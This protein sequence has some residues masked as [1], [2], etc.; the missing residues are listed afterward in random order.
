MIE[1][2]SREEVL[3]GCRK[4]LGLRDVDN[5]VV[6]DDL[7]T[8]LVRRSAG[9]HCPCSRTAL[10]GSLV[11]ALQHLSDSD[12]DLAD[13][14]ESII[15]GLIVVG[16]L[17]ELH[18]V[19]IVDP[20]VRGT[21]VFAAPPS[22]VERESGEI[23][24]IGIVADQDVFLPESFGSRVSMRGLTRLISP[25]VNENLAMKLEDQGLQRLSEK[26]WLRSPNT[27][28][29]DQVLARFE[30][31]LTE[32]PQAGIVNEIEILDGEQPVT[33]YRG[34][35]SDRT[36]KNGI[37]VGR[38]PQEYGA[39]IWCLVE[40]ASG[41]VIRF[42]DLP[43]SKSRWRGCDE[44]WHLQMA[45]DARSGQPQRYRVQRDAGDLRFDF[46]SPLPAWS[47]RRFVA[48]GRAVPRQ[49]CLMSYVLSSSAAEIEERFL[50]ECLWLSRTEESK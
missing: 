20:D 28:R 25:E 2:I 8:A 49:K 36:G 10:R 5:A 27:E 48:F 9:I 38:R 47:E 32:R 44:A 17:L 40:L 50:R 26:T 46:F 18:D 6:D 33:F 12:A 31:R 14:V 21:W 42:L 11:E 15:E 1:D 22:Y 3:A 4:F 34:R 19:G 24:I 13:R 39:P 43:A 35:W 30:R 45:I 29:F 37:F 41:N 7:L 23:F 16:D